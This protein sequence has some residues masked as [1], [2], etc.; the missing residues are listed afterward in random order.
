MPQICEQVTA[1][2]CAEFERE[3]IQMS[4]AQG[5]CWIPATF[6][7]SVSCET[8]IGAY[9]AEL[10]VWH[11]V[12][13]SQH[14]GWSP[15]VFVAGLKPQILQNILK[16]KSTYRVLGVTCW[17]TGC[18]EDCGGQR[19]KR[20]DICSTKPSILNPLFGPNLIGGLEH[21]IFSIYWEFHHP[22]SQ[23]TNSYFSRWLKPPTRQQ[24][25][26]HQRTV[27]KSTIE[28]IPIYPI[29]PPLSGWSDWK[30]WILK[31]APM[32]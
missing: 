11:I 31:I 3:V 17:N 12:F 20:R 29:V 5:W 26:T 4:E 18:V 8:C 22:N 10:M 15:F 32:K 2:L 21:F 9:N 24:C 30:H 23:L 16:R 6:Q 19:L 1:S 13:S 7:Q 28:M 14:M 25:L 27:S